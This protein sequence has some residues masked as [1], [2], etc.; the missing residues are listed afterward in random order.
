DI[1]SITARIRGPRWRLI[2]PPTHIHYFTRK[3]IATLLDRLGY[4]NPRFYYHPFWRSAD[5]A[6]R[7]LLP[8]PLYTRLQ[9]HNLLAFNFPLN[10]FDIMT[11]Y[12]HKG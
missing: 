9:A 11:V 4:S 6:C 3:S 10:L 7:A 2:H 5:A 1:G 12:A 8:T